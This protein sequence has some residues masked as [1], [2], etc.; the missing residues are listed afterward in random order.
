VCGVENPF[1]LRLKFYD[2]GPGEVTAEYTVPTEYQSYP[3]MVHG[4]VIAAMLDET[5]G[6]TQMGA[7]PPRFMFT[8]RL[9]IRYRKNVP[10]GEPLRLVGRALGS[11]RRTATASS[12][13]YDME[14]N[15]LAE[16][17][18]VLVNVPEDMVQSVDLDALGWRVYSDEEFK[19]DH[20]I[21]SPQY[22]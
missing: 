15:L 4:G 1:G 12:A 16:A 17:K 20:R 3:G 7:D 2:T 9:D 6:R 21:P 14:D 5:A 19:N 11:K 10:V 18:A 13:I 8:A 22:D